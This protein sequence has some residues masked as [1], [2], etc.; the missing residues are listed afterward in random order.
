VHGIDR[1]LALCPYGIAL[2]RWETIV[3]L[4]TMATTVAV[5]LT[6]AGAAAILSLGKAASHLAGYTWSD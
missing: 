6:A 2:D 1:V 3:R 4:R 5:L